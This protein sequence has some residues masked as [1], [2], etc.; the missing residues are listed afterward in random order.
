[1]NDSQ[2][3]DIR[4]K[5]PNAT[6]LRRRN[7]HQGWRDAASGHVYSDTT[8]KDLTWQNL[9]NR[10]GKLFPETSRGLVDEM[11]DWCVRQQKER[12]QP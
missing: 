10:L 2:L 8:L 12:G 1:M 5:D 6:A 9:G 11:Y 3:D 7:F 4:S